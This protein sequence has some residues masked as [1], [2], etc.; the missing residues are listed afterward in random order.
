MTALVSLLLLLWSLLIVKLQNFIYTFWLTF[1]G[2]NYKWAHTEVP[3]QT[4]EWSQI[5]FLRV[6]YQITKRS[7]ANEL[8]ICLWSPHYTALQ[9]EK[10]TKSM[11]SISSCYYGNTGTIHS[12]Q[13]TPMIDEPQWKGKRAI[14]LCFQWCLTFYKHLKQRIVWETF[15]QSL[16]LLSL[17]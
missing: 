9:T 7:Y 3:F 11:K 16:Q 5:L 10:N 4:K 12:W 14:M 1:S 6:P 17:S 13:C 8:R 2:N 15:L